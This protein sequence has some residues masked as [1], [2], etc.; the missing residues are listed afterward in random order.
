MLVKLPAIWCVYTTAWTRSEAEQ[1]WLSIEMPK[2]R[3][4]P[5]TLVDHFILSE[6]VRGW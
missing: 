4:S 3:S 2:H 5:G 6:N 1:A